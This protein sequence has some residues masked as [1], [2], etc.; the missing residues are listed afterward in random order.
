MD[1]EPSDYRRYSTT[2]LHSSPNG[3]RE[4]ISFAR[5]WR[6]PYL[7]S[8]PK[9]DTKPIPPFSYHMESEILST[10]STYNAHTN[11]PTSTPLTISPPSS[12]HQ[13]KSN[14]VFKIP[15]SPSPVFLLFLTCLHHIV[16]QHPCRFEYNDYLLVVLAR[17]ASGASPF[18]DFLYNNEC[19]RSQDKMRQRTP[20]IWKWIQENQGWFKNRDYVP[21]PNYRS[22]TK[23]NTQNDTRWREQV[24]QVQ[25]GG[26]FVSIWSEYYFNTTPTWLPDPCTVLSTALF[27]SEGRDRPLLMSLQRQVGLCTD[28]WYSSQFDPGQL[29]K[30]TFPGL[31]ST[32]DQLYQHQ[33]NS[34]GHPR[35]TDLRTIPPVLAQ[36]S[37]QDMHLYYLLVQR[38]RERRRKQV[39]QAFLKWQSWAKRRLEEKPA[40]EDGWGLVGNSAGSSQ[41]D[42]IPEHYDSDDG[43]DDEYGSSRVTTPELK[44]VMAK[45]GIEMAMERVLEGEPFF[46]DGPLA[47]EPESDNEDEIRDSARSDSGGLNGKSKDRL[48]DIEALEDSLEGDFDDFGFPVTTDD[49]ITV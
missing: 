18:G 49:Y 15:I 14:P 22:Q 9:I 19:E 38:L 4:S 24:L 46:G 41:D 43:Y 30:L 48:L 10:N 29:Q 20:S 12:P 37:G 25:T 32:P 6:N 16:Q 2:V 5:K 31:H 1:D 7:E 27:H 35:T 44:V 17:A 8:E 28:P 42:S 11:Y 3:S 36:L 39:K 45:M 26:R 13:S 34:D 33:P 47:F 40:R 23:A 21:E